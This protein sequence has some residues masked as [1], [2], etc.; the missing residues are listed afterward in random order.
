MLPPK[1]MT[2]ENGCLACDLT[3][4][5][6]PLPGGRIH[7]TGGWVVEHCIGPLPAG[8]LIVKPLRHCVAIAELTDG[9]AAALG[10]LLRL[11][12]GVIADLTSCDQVYICLWSHLGWTPGHIHFVLPPAWDKQREEHGKPGLFMQAAMF[13]GGEPLHERERE[14]F[15]DRARALFRQR[16]GVGAGDRL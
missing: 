10:P 7:E 15:S 12:S 4:G 16:P 3:A 2:H 6:R 9:E 13:A 8:T 14:E 1:G 5:K 11:T